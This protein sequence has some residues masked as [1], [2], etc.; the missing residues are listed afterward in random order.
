MCEKK[1]SS[2]RHLSSSSQSSVYFAKAEKV[3]KERRKRISKE[4]IKLMMTRRDFL[5]SWECDKMVQESHHII[6]INPRDNNGSRE[7]AHHS[8]VQAAKKNSNGCIEDVTGKAGDLLKKVPPCTGEWLLYSSTWSSHQ[9]RVLRY[10]HTCNFES[11]QH[12]L[13]VPPIKVR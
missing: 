10:P 7:Q 13:C 3:E 9:T 5:S 6:Q 11:S 1:R 12:S 2:N 8:H 4:E